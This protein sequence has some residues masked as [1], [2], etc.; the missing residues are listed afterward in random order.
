MTVIKARQAGPILKR[1]STIHLADHLA[2]ADQ[3]IRNTKR[4]ALQIA[5]DAE[6]EADQARTAAIHA[7]YEAGYKQGYEEG[8]KAGHQAAHEEAIERFERQQDHLVATMQE[9]IAR[10]DAIKEDLQ[11]AAEKDL[12]DFA[13]QLA[14]KL[15]FAIGRLHRESA[16]ENLERALRLVGSRTDLS[17]CVH[18]D[19]VAAMK[20]F[21]DSVLKRADTSRAV[22]IVPDD[23]LAPGGCKVTDEHTSVDATLE[24]QVDEIVAL[25]LGGGKPDA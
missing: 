15:T 8:T 12:L 4:H 25:L 23:S 9:A 14:S 19:D 21:A 6:R 10:I 18:P 24:T 17:I 13:V 3:A 11:I 7:G 16:V 20:T 2:E 1:L 5:R 22:E